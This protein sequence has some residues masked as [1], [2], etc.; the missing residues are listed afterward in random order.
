MSIKY[1]EV[2]KEIAR[3]SSYQ[4]E[5]LKLLCNIATKL[6]CIIYQRT[7]LTKAALSPEIKEETA[8]PIKRK[9]GRPFKKR[10]SLKEE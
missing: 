6:D 9:R 8:E 10:L 5:I 2:Q 3:G 1:E 7:V 4:H